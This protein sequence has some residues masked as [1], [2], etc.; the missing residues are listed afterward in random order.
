MPSFDEELQAL[1]AGGPSFEDELAGLGT[2]QPAADGF[3]SWSGPSQIPLENESR[4]PYMDPER[5]DLWSRFLDTTGDAAQGFAG[6]SFSGLGINPGQMV[7]TLSPELGAGVR[8]RQQL[9]QDRSPADFGAGKLIGELAPAAMLA[10][11]QLA[12]AP[13]SAAVGQG[14]LSELGN[15]DSA[16]WGE[17]LYAMTRGAAMGGA[18]GLGARALG[19]TGELA[20]EKV[21]PWLQQ[22]GYMNRAASAVD[23]ASRLGPPAEQ[24]RLGQWMEEQGL[25]E[26]SGPLGFLPQSQTAVRGNVAQFADDMTSHQR[27]LRQGATDAGV[28]VDADPTIETL[29]QFAEG[30]EAIP[31]KPKQSQAEYALDNAALVRDAAAPGGGQLPF[32]QA[33]QTRK[34][35]D[36]SAGWQYGQPHETTLNQAVAR[37]GANELRGGLQHSLDTQAPEL[38]A[39]W[40]Q[41]QGDLSNALDLLNPKNA[42]DES[43]GATAKML[44]RR[45][46]LPLVGGS[47]GY[48]FGGAAGGPVGMAGA[49][50]VSELV[51]TRGSS[52]LAGI[53]GAASRGLSAAGGGVSSASG[54]AGRTGAVMSGQ[55]SDTER[56]EATEKARGYL[57]GQAAL[58]S[59]HNGSQ[60]LGPYASKFAEAAAS[61]DTSAVANLISRL[62]MS[63]PEFRVNYL[64]ALQRM[65]AAG[66]F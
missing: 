34:A 18:F 43:L 28:M 5:Q 3:S 4:T 41:T 61:P 7:D 33:F 60:D 56:E 31:L 55:Q 10:G 38:G 40:S 53:E 42:P 24:A 22:R 13:I 62:V 47:A 12:A 2:P 6:G 17:R 19:A 46:A 21:A 16:D 49:A 59:L 8:A 66:G 51:R 36:N 27:G 63:D 57:L 9:A 48:A 45:S 11:P 15:T 65:T 35:Y 26:G 30:A 25:H 58:D 32:E 64:P 54:L 14:A 50:A 37:A 52:A 23:D 1:G 39:E 20:A 29:R 44:M